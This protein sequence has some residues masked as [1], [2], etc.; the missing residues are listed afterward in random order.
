MI[1]SVINTILTNNAAY[2]TEIGSDP[3][4]G[5]KLYPAGHVPQKTKRPYAVFTY[6]TKTVEQDKNKKG[7]VIY[8]YQVD[9]FATT[10]DQAEKL[11]DLCIAAL[12]RYRGTV[13]GKKVDQ[14]REVDGGSGFSPDQE[15]TR[16]TSEFTIRINP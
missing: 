1:S 6:V 10:V 15:S 4:S 12:N 5:I 9:Q 14:I 11:D 16:R 2:A 7:V 8:L 13:N 3:I